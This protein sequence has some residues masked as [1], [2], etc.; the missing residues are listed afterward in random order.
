ME[1]ELQT[2][3]RPVTVTTYPETKH[4]FFEENRPEYDAQAARV[5]WERTI[6]FL[7]EQLE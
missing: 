2:A 6:R 1:R 4:W 3:G 5:A 7:H